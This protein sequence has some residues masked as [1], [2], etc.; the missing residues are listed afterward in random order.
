MK[1]GVGIRAKP[2]KILGLPYPP[3]SGW[4]RLVIGKTLTDDEAEC[5]YLLR[6]RKPIPKWLYYV[7]L[8]KNSCVTSEELAALK[9]ERPKQ[10][11]PKTTTENFIEHY[12][13]P[14]SMYK[15]T[16][17]IADRMKQLVIDSSE[18]DK[19]VIYAVIRM[20]PYG[21]FLQTPYWKVIAE[22][23]KRCAG[24]KCAICG[25][26]KNLNLHHTTYKNHGD[27]ICHLDDLVTVCQSCH[28]DIHGI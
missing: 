17:P 6:D 26:T 5:F 2:C 4:R 14:K 9:K 23:Q 18:C 1:S 12:L 22:N 15:A 7:L 21:I 24:K 11:V 13:N 20:L 27:E 8:D 25:S 28:K 10:K 3:P 19:K 16:S